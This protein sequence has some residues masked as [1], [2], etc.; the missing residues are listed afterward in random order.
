VFD[1]APP[2]SM[3]IFTAS[4]AAVGWPSAARGGS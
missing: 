3:S 1:P 4:S 2:T